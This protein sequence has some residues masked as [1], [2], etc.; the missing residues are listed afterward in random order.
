MHFVHS[1]GLVLLL[2]CTFAVFRSFVNPVYIASL[3]PK[4]A[5]CS[6]NSKLKAFDL[7]QHI[8]TQQTPS[9]FV[10]VYVLKNYSSNVQ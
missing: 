2:L 6:Y 9:L 8:N 10:I 5:L 4:S 7:H 1:C 3:F